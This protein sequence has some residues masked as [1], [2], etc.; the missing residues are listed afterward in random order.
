MATV[1]GGIFSYPENASLTQIAQDKLPALQQDRRIFEIMPID[2]RD[3]STIIWEQ[4]DNYTGLQELRGVGGAFPIIRSPG[5]KQYVERPGYYGEGTVIDEAQL[6]DRRRYGTFGDPVSIDDLVVEQQDLLL[7][8][9]LDRIEWIGWQLLT[10]GYFYVVSRTG[11]VHTGS[12][13]IQSYTSLVPWATSATAT[14]LADFR[15]V[16]ILARGHSTSFGAGAKAY[17][18]QVTANRL[19]A[20][21]NAADLYGRRTAGLGTFNNMR[22][23]SELMVGDDLPS[24]VIYEDGYL[25]E[26][27]AFSPFIP[28]GKVVVVGPRPSGQAVCQYIMTRNVSE[29]TM[30]PGMYMYIKD[31][32]QDGDAPTISVYSSHNGG[33]IIE[34]PSS[35]VV[36]NV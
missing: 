27:G 24:I 25:D 1:V 16:K 17:M 31:D 34:Y 14:P 9:M 19:L 22:Q 11:L 15:S 8:R 4:K 5:G 7:Q 26:N 32:R 10:F 2:T 23:V 35:V 18:N 6:A 13:K 21:I 33:P 29:P 20:N 12:Y 36:M 30:A 3:S 28:N